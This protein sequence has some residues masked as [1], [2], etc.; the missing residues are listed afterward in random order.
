MT[1]GKYCESFSPIWL[2]KEYNKED[3]KIELRSRK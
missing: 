2:V 1:F 3:K